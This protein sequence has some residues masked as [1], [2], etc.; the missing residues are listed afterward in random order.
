MKPKHFPL[1]PIIADGFFLEGN[2]RN[3][4]E[5]GYTGIILMEIIGFSIYLIEFL[6]YFSFLTQ[7]MLEQYFYYS[8]VCWRGYPLKASLMSEV[9][10]LNF[11]R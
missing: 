11:L 1:I 10:L 8:E 3:M 7:R 5:I 6:E 9:W 2:E 4:A